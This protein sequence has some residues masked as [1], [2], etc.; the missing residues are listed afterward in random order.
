MA[1]LIRMGIEVTPQI[2]GALK[3]QRNSFLKEFS[4]VVV[5]CAEDVPTEPTAKAS[6]KSK[7]KPA[8]S[9]KKKYAIELQDTILFPEGG[10]QP[11]DQGFIIVE[12]G[13][14]H[15]VEHVRRDKLSAVHLVDEPMEPGTSV[16]LELDWKR[17]MDH[18]QQ[19]TGQHLLSAVLDSYEIPTLSWSMGEMVNYIELPRSLSEEEVEEVSA[20]VNERIM[21]G[22]SI[23]VETPEKDNVK[24]DKLPD[25]YDVDKGVLRVIKI[26]ELDKNPCC[27]THLQSTAQI[28]S[29]ALLHQTP[30]RGSNSRLHFIAGDRVRQYATQSHKILKQSS[31]ELSCQ[32][33]DITDKI[34]QLNLNYRKFTKKEATWKEEVAKY[35][36]LD[37]LSQLKDK[38]VAHLYRADAGL[39]YLTLIFKA[40]SKEQAD[41]KCVVLISGQGKEGGSVIINSSD[42]EKTMAIAKHLQ[43]L[44]PGLR[45]GGKTKWQG[46]I[47]EFGKG[48]LEAALDYLKSA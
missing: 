11:S 41:G 8:E 2:V 17:R 40:T 10:G 21:E 14:R 7:S 34:G 6:K 18:M 4:T 43:S 30:V 31:Q 1:T 38:D 24:Q 33:E 27:G 37:I 9:S 29:I 22:I 16:K 20:K 44:I 13:Q 5:H 23:T 45:G 26:G 28:L 25:D 36:S 12:S 48:E 3:C 39:D 46:K 15:F 42:A 35:Q 19:H 47:T 32:F